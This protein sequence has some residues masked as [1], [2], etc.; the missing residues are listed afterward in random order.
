MFLIVFTVKMC[1][2]ESWMSMAV[3]KQKSFCNW[4]N[5]PFQNRVCL[6][7]DFQDDFEFR[8]RDSRFRLHLRR[9]PPKRRS[10]K[11]RTPR[12]TWASGTPGNEGK[13]IVVSFQGRSSQRWG[14]KNKVWWPWKEIR[15]HQLLIGTHLLLF[16]KLRDFNYLVFGRAIFRETFFGNLKS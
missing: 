1:K 16:F 10:P 12:A 7:L 15:Q 14:Q 11:W 3:S 2:F 6:Q 5:V 8:C 13:S 4:R 9:R